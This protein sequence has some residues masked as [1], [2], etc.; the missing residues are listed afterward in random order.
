MPENKQKK[1]SNEAIK[2]QQYGKNQSWYDIKESWFT[3]GCVYACYS[4]RPLLTPSSV[5]HLS[6]LYQNVP[7]C[8]HHRV[9]HCSWAG[10]QEQAQL[11]Q[12]LMHHSSVLP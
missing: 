8:H 11:L 12:H 3:N 6:S 10:L 5:D 1:E 7:D 4:I 2:Y 9:P